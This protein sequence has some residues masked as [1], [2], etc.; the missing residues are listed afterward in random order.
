MV[1]LTS[2][3]LG[4]KQ[5]PKRVV[6]EFE[7]PDGGGYSLK[8]AAFKPNVPILEIG[9]IYTMEY[10]EK[11]TGTGGKFRN[12]SRTMKDGPYKIQEA[13]QEG[14]EAYVDDTIPTQNPPSNVISDKELLTEVRAVRAE[15]SQAQSLIHEALNN[16]KQKQSTE[17]WE[18]RDRSIIRQACVK[19]AAQIVANQKTENAKQAIET[20][21]EIAEA[22]ASYCAGDEKQ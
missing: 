8:I 7:N 14:I 3:L 18:K 17:Y 21:L 12:L 22:L 1:V 6:F 20:T 11:D 10:T 2:K 15:L 9:K 4:I 19:A 16:L 5:E 13:G